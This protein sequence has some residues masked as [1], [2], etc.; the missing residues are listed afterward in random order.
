MFSSTRTLFLC[1]LFLLCLS[2]VRAL[3]VAPAGGG[4]DSALLTTA[5]IDRTRS[6]TPGARLANTISSVGV[7]AASDHWA[8]AVELK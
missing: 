7:L 5:P 3:A 2:S 4:V 1:T 8:E 6:T